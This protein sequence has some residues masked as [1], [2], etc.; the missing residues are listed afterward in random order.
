M[1]AGLRAGGAG[2]LDAAACGVAEPQRGDGIPEIEG[3]AGPIHAHLGIDVDVGRASPS[4]ENL[5][6]RTQELPSL[7]V[8]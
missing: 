3:E 1:L 4:Q 7:R 5:S 6:A 2:K 8:A